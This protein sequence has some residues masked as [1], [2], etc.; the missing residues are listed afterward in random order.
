MRH[1]L[2]LIILTGVLVGRGISEEPEARRIRSEPLGEVNRFLVIGRHCLSKGS[3]VFRLVLGMLD[4][5][6]GQES[7]RC[8]SIV[9]GD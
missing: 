5:F 9:Q 7:Y 6:V 4:I 8:S 3:E 2:G 1:K